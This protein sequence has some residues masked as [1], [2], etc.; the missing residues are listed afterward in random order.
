MRNEGGLLVM[1]VKY[2]IPHR[3][4]AVEVHAGVVRPLQVVQ[5]AALN[6]IVGTVVDEIIVADEVHRSRPVPCLVGPLDVGIVR[7]VHG[8]TSSLRK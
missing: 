2:D 5:L 3:G 8:Q 1:V 6:R 4:C 7:G